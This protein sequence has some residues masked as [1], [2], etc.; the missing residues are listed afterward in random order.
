MLFLATWWFWLVA[1]ETT[2]IFWSLA[3]DRGDCASLSLIV[4][5]T[6]LYLIPGGATFYNWVSA[7]PSM[8]LWIALVYFPLG[9]VWGVCKWLLYVYDKLDE[10]KAV[11]AGFETH[12]ENK[13]ETAR[14]DLADAITIGKVPGDL[15]DIDNLFILPDRELVLQEY[16][17]KEFGLKWAIKYPPQIGE[18]KADYIRW[19]GYWPFSIIY[20]FCSD[21]VRRI[22]RVIYNAISERMQRMSEWVFA[23]A[24]VELP[25]PGKY[26]AKPARSYYR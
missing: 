2:I 20:T 11:L 6:I 25:P 5:L 22:A 7:N 18:H 21:F 17:K 3:Y 15:D 12:Y 16:L 10:Y 26:D 8:L 13:V 19:A 9:A 23:K 24:K 14:K 1:I 4:F